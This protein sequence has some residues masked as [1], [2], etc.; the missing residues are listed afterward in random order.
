VIRDLLTDHASRVG[1]NGMSETIVERN[2]PL[3]LIV[4]DDR[5]IRLVLRH[6]LEQH[7]YAVLEAENGVQGVSAYESQQPDLVLLDVI[8]PAMDGFDTCRRLRALPGGDR[9]PVLMITS[10]DD[11][12]SIDKAFEA[13]ATDYIT[14][15]IHLASVCHRVG[16]LLRARQVENGI[17]RAKKE[18]EATFD[19]VSDLII[20]TDVEGKIIRCNRSTIERFRTTYNEM[21]GRSIWTLLFGDS[22]A[23]ACLSQPS[24]EKIRIPSLDG[25][26]EISNDPVHLQGDLYGVVYI[27]KDVTER[28]QAA[29]A[30]QASEAKFRTLAETTAAATFIYQDTRM[31]YVNSAAETISGYTRDELV[32]MSFWEVI[33]PDFQPLARHRGL[34]RQRGENAHIPARYEL[35]LLTKNGEERWVDFMASTIEFEGRTAVL[36]TAFDITERKRAEESLRQSEE[37]FRKIFEEGPLGISI[38]GPNYRFVKTNP[39][40]RQML[41]YTEQELNS[42]TPLDVTHPE[43]VDANVQLSQQLFRGDIPYFNLEKRYI[44]KSGEIVWGNLT[45]SV[46]R[47]ETGEPLYS[48]AMVED[49]TERKEISERMMEAQKLADLGTLAAGVAH[50]MNSP[51]QVITGMSKSLLNH[52]DQGDLDPERLRRN[53]D[54]IHRNGWR[55]AE[56]VRALRTYTHATPRP[57][58]PNDLNT[59]VQDGL[60]L[61]EHQLKSWSNISIITNLAPDLPPLWCDHNQMIQVL[62]NLITNARDAL[63]H[64]GDITIRTSYDPASARLSLQVADT[65]TGMPESVRAKIFDPFFTTKPLGRGSGLGLSIVLGIVRAHE[66]EIDVHSAPGQGTTFTMYF[67]EKV[68]DITDLLPP[69]AGGRFDD[70]VLDKS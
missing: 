57:F 54:V 17:I 60:L 33:H 28:K 55:C 63:P 21:L 13:G 48:I 65:G 39:R 44:K 52:L 11:E 34:A 26:F 46:I 18:W 50:E 66:G 32:G 22:E 45:A 20:L 37:R 67:P 25:W 24:G 29:E 19:A 49:I 43:D 61:V 30:L 7:G 1:K 31:R 14:K 9:I 6:V 23:D 62:I 58:E 5:G 53:L 70:V 47:G 51:L 64:G 35:K 3:V 36:G 38:V 16:W 42:L 56:I 68:F 12:P 40:L 59:L 41:G 4:D 69:D 8:M 2:Q 15:P 27:I 10:L